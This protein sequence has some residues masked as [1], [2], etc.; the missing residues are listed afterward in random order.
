MG[1]RGGEP[2]IAE[3]K[4]PECGVKTD[5]AASKASTPFRKTE[6]KARKG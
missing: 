2:E 5:N 1:E 4:P 6:G 3:V